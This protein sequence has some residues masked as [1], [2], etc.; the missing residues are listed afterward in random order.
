MENLESFTDFWLKDAYY[1]VTDYLKFAGG[2]FILFY[3]ILRKPLWF[4]KI[5][6]KMPRYGDYF[7]D[8]IFSLIT[9]VIFATVSIYTLYV[10]DPYNHVYSTID[11]Y[12]LGYYIF[13]YIWMFFLHDAYFYWMH[14]LMH[15]PWLFRK[16]HLIHHRSTN[17][18]PWTAYSFH[19]LEALIEVGIVPLIA[20]T[21]P[22]HYS[23]IVAF[24]IFQI[25]FNVYGHLGFEIF[26]RKFHKTLIGRWIN[27]SV[28]HN[29][30]HKRFT[31]NYS[32]YFLFW[33]R[34]LGTIR[35]DY[36]ETYEETTERKKASSPNH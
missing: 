7:R 24:F 33:D 11:Q 17:P 19:P 29:L 10:L 20:F 12:G 5:Q 16:V 22:V 2:A 1:I 8:I 3:V 21:L 4:R 30:H 6:Q 27:T 15:H 18:S 23:A 36:D 25:A 9:V 34:M 32:L 31:G 28:A 14:R 26:P 35:P 13:T